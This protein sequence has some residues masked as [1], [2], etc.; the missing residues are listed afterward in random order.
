[1][2]IIWKT[3]KKLDQLKVDK[4]YD[5][6]KGGEINFEGFYTT[7][8]DIKIR[9]KFV[10]DLLREE[11]RKII[12][13]A[14]SDLG[15][16]DHID[17]IN[18]FW[19][20]M[21]ESRTNGHEVHEHFSGTEFF[22]WVHFVQTPNQKCFYFIDSDGNKTYPDH[23][24]SGD[25]IIFPPWQPHGV[26]IVET[27]DVSRIVVAGNV[28]VSEFRGRRGNNWHSVVEQTGQ[29]TWKRIIKKSFNMMRL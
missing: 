27:S 23:Q 5:H 6:L 24:S 4:I 25:F 18:P 3:H 26:D 9:R 8:Y 2:S 17:Y 1:M 10:E 28:A 11:Y 15:L 7:Y 19:V 22:S 29:V 13:K 12:D 16:K 14:L 21:Y 20:Q